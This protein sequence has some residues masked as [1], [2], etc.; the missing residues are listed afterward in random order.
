MAK[1]HME[2]ICMS[3][4]GLCFIALIRALVTFKHILI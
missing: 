3:F 2:N 1:Y 4:W